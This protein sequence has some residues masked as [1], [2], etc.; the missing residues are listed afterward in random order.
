[1]PNSVKKI[2]LELVIDSELDNYLKVIIQSE[3]FKTGY[4]AVNEVIVEELF[5]D[6]SSFEKILNEKD[7]TDYK[8][9]REFKDF[10]AK[11]ADTDYSKYVEYKF[12]DIPLSR[13]V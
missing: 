13:N 7:E 6:W 2:M 8:Y 11:F 9:L 5:G 4:Y 10:Y 12:K 1:M 3:S